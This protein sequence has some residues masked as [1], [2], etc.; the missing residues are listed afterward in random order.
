MMKLKEIGSEFWEANI[1]ADTLCSFAS[2]YSF[3]KTYLAGRTALTAIIID[4]KHRGVKSV[5]VPEY[6]CESIIEPFLQQKLE[7]RFYSVKK[8]GM[9]L[10]ISMDEALVSDA[11]LLVNYFGFMSSR[12][13]TSILE[14][15]NAGKIIIID[16]THAVFADYEN[17]YADYVYGSFRKWTGVEVGFAAGCCQDHLISWQLNKTGLKYLKL[18]QDARR[19][20]SL[21]VSSGYCD[22]ELRKN[23]LSFFKN[24][25]ELLDREYISGTDEENLAHIELLNSNFIKEKRKENAKTVYSYFSHLKICKP[26]F[27][28]LSGDVVPLV[29]PIMVPENRRDSLWN[30]LRGLGI[31]CPIHWPISQLHEIGYEGM[32]LYREELSLVCDQ[33]YDISDMARMMEMVRKWEMTTSV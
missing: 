15:R 6:C 13:R 14:S 31:F 11:I 18:R 29:I 26:M 9:G 4:L 25:E 21:F 30:F 27:S 12:I 16:N 23:Q 28:E 20:K 1:V 32:K 8:D 3:Q 7:I 10:T 19:I 33:R 24:A 5:C 2:K 17:K 22:E